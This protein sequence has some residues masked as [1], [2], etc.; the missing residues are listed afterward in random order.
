MSTFVVLWLYFAT[1]WAWHG[2]PM[3]P[4]W[5]SVAVLDAEACGEAINRSR[6]QAVC[7][8]PG[9]FLFPMATLLGNE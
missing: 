1:P 4:G 9:V 2:M 3:G 5:A 6:T 7:A 8:E